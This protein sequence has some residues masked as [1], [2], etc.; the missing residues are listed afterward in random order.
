MDGGNPAGGSLE[1]AS[2]ID[3][4]GETLLPELKH[5]FGIDIRELFSDNPPFS[6]RYVIAHIKWLPLGS[7]FVAETRG[8]K[9]F[10]DWDGDRYL[11]VAQFD[12]FRTFSYL[13]ILA[14]K[15][16]KKSAPKPP[17]PYPIPDARVRVK[18]DEKPNS[19]GFIAKS[20]LADAKRKKAQ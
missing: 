3:Q 9:Q 17:D 5:Y 4:Y 15:D 11:R 18:K 14:N 6:P 16:P 19:F 13:F 12:A 10:R 8:G 1:L 7:A 20:M 2:L